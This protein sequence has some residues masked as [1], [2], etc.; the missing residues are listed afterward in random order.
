MED[1]IIQAIIIIIQA[2]ILIFLSPL[3]I[4]IIRKIEAHLQSRKGARI[5]QPYYD[6]RKLFHK[7]SVIS[8]EASWIFSITPYIC[9]SAVIVIALMVPVFYSISFN[10][11]GNIIVLV[12][13]LAL[14]RFFMALA[15]IDV[16]STFTGMGSSREMMISA[17]AEP[18]ILLSIF[19]L[20]LITK[21]TYLGGISS[22]YRQ[23]F[24]Y[25]FK[26]E[27]FSGIFCILHY[28]VG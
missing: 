27:S 18:T 12:S 13:L 11:I 16:N 14:M 1:D 10:L 26:S 22:I 5:L 2:L 17:I 9:M 7:D 23:F 21:T 3:V 8:K 19:T 25:R 28:H 20:A 6:L 15:A 24:F 4:G